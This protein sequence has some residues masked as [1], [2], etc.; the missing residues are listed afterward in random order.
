MVKSGFTTARNNPIFIPMSNQNKPDV[1]KKNLFW[2]KPG[3]KLNFLNEENVQPSTSEKRKNIKDS[4]SENQ[5][6]VQ[7]PIFKRKKNNEDSGNKVYNDIS[8]T[9]K[10]DRLEFSN[11]TF[12]NCV[13]NVVSCECN[14][15][16]KR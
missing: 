11:C 6:A 2:E 12:N 15:E 13:F 7:P 9:L 3:I 16:N 4:D 10:T 1:G 8:S 14:K 5:A